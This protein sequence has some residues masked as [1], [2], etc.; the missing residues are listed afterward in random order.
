MV[1]DRDVLTRFILF[2]IEFSG[3]SGRG[4][5]Y[6]IGNWNGETGEEA[7]SRIMELAQKRCRDS[8]RVLIDF[9]EKCHLDPK[10]HSDG[11]G[12]FQDK[13]CY[14]RVDC[15]MVRSKPLCWISIV[16][17]YSGEVLLSEPCRTTPEASTYGSAFFTKQ[18]RPG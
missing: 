1:M 14:L 18:G 10:P 6:S 3:K 16:D 2:R 11:C 9:R 15:R 4:R 12:H 5:Q 13:Y 7:V 8:A 17:H